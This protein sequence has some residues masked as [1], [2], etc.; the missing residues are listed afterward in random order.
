MTVLTHLNIL[1]LLL[2]VV[3]GFARGDPFTPITYEVL[4]TKSPS[5]NIY[6]KRTY[7]S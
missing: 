4:T 3:L 5:E 6:S 2:A 7:D 1:F